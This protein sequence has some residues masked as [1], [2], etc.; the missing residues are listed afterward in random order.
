M[1]EGRVNDE[2]AAS[3]DRSQEEEAGALGRCGLLRGGCPRTWC[4]RTMVG[5]HV[6]GLVDSRGRLW[7]HRYGSHWLVNQIV[8]VASLQT[9]RIEMHRSHSLDSDDESI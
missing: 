5:E 9:F 7:V 4:F 1:E 2:T 3:L 6:G 8:Y